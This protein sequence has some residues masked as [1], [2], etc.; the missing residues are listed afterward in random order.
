MRDG[1][2]IGVASS[3]RHPPGVVILPSGPQGTPWKAS[4]ER[5][6]TGEKLCDRKGEEEEGTRPEK[7][8]EGERKRERSHKFHLPTLKG[9]WV[10]FTPLHLS[11]LAERGR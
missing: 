8:R 3:A 5:R 2:T 4:V 11:L 9:Q 1:L 7:E 6:Q 10:S